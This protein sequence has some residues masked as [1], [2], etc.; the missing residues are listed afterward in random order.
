MYDEC[1]FLTIKLKRQNDAL[2]CQRLNQKTFKSARKVLYYAR[3]PP[4]FETC[5]DMIFG[6]AH[7]KPAVGPGGSEMRILSRCLVVQDQ[8]HRGE[9]RFAHPS[10]LAWDLSM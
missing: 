10:N 8:Q 9:L 1:T 2:K 3:A 7:T 4:V 6:L 5:N